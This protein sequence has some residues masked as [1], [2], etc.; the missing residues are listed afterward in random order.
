MSR[1][2][3]ELLVAWAA[4]SLAVPVSAE[5]IP[6]HGPRDPR[7]RYARYDADEVYR[8]IGVVGYAI[9]LVFE[10]GEKFVGQG[11]G[12][13]EG[14][15]I[16]AHDQF[17][18]VKPHAELVA[19]NLVI[20]TSRRAYR[21]DYSVVEAAPRDGL[22]Y[23][24][25]FQYTPVAVAAASGPTPAEQ[26]E[27]KLSAAESERWRNV[28]YWYCG[29]PSLKPVAASDDGVH[30]RL[31]FGP[32]AEI[33]ALFVLNEDGT[34]SLLNFSMEGG[35]VVI[36][37]VA[38]RLVLRRGKLTGCIVN[39]GYAGSGARLESG[40]VSPQVERNRTGVP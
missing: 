37:R 19:T 1:R 8:L 22:V 16:D 3:R 18:L 40:T 35:D 24:V 34:E 29:H 21:F 36:H 25:K 39:R 9:E 30:T 20:Y 6:T 26:I 5:S 15:S 23:A 7:I 32:R 12:D 14:V 11:G 13:L 10:D 28:D 33:P 31:A 38:P 27:Q 4:L 17:V 2:W